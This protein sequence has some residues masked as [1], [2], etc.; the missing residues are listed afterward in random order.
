[1]VRAVLGVPIICLFHVLLMFDIQLAYLI[2][3]PPAR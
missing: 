3:S 1:M 2:F